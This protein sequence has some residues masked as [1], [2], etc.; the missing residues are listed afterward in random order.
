MSTALPAGLSLL[1]FVAAAV[2]WRTKSVPPHA[3]LGTLVVAVSG[4]TEWIRDQAPITS[5]VLLLLNIA[6][7][8]MTIWQWWRWRHRSTPQ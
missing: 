1:L 2:L 8:A 4:M 5:R 3:T 7:T 6:L